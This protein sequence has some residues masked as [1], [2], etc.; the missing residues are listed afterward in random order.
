MSLRSWTQHLVDDRLSLP[1]IG[2]QPQ[3]HSSVRL[4]RVSRPLDDHD[5]DLSH[6]AFGSA[7]SASPNYGLTTPRPGTLMLNLLIGRVTTSQPQPFVCRPAVHFTPHV[8]S[9]SRPHARIGLLAI[10]SI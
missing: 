2:L 10:T 6:E 3:G 1:L 7:R 9:Q 8:T 5:Q 4:L